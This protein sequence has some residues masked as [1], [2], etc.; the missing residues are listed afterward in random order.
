M[1]QS[2]SDLSLGASGKACPP[3]GPDGAQKVDGVCPPLP[4]EFLPKIMALSTP[5]F[6]T[7]Y[8]YGGTGPGGF[9]CSGF[10]AY[11]YKQ[12][13]IKLPRG[14]YNQLPL[15][16]PVAKGDLRPGDLLFFKISRRAVV[17]HVGIYI[18]NDQMVHASIQ[19]GV[20]IDRVFGD[21]YYNRHYY[22][23]RR[24]PQVEAMALTASATK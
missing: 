8:K 14:S 7:R 16:K 11:V 20:T 6:G 9:D 22:G 23:A 17:T 24:L 4:K 19:K 18:G 1:M 21:N 3:L 15:G 12:F 5:H 13:G 10:T 2:S